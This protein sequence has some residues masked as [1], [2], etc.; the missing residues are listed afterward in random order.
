ML[1]G[2]SIMTFVCDASLPANPMSLPGKQSTE[3]TS[4]L[5]KS[6]RFSPDKALL[7]D[8]SL[9]F[10]SSLFP[11]KVQS[12]FWGHFPHH[13]SN[14]F[15][16]FWSRNDYQET[17]HRI[18]QTIDTGNKRATT[19]NKQRIVLNGACLLVTRLALLV[20]Y[21]LRN[22]NQSVGQYWQTLC[23]L[24]SSSFNWFR[25][26]VAFVL[27]LNWKSIVN[28]FQSNFSFCLAR[29][30][31]DS[32]L[33]WFCASARL[34]GLR[35][36][37]DDTISAFL[38]KAVYKKL[39]VKVIYLSLW[40]FSEWTISGR[41]WRMF[42]KWRLSSDVAET[43]APSLIRNW[44]WMTAGPVVEKLAD[45]WCP[46]PPEDA[47]SKTR[48]DSQSKWIFNCIHQ[49]IRYQLFIS[50]ILRLFWKL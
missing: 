37:A 26:A 30:C 31:A 4:A 40:N 32:P 38:V 29:I 46:K 23:A 2:S 44:S 34:Q 41:F 15:A 36:P 22:Q 28:I 6:P 13:D 49:F 24:E 48:K 17:R 45:E 33:D 18:S 7:H 39:I 14:W 25:N 8:R 5:K 19:G 43:N 16:I 21:L 10:P 50:S 11:T 42:H 35:P 9:P 20:S 47:Y 1:S 3:H 27:L 12:P